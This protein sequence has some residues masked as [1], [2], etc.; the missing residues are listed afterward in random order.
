[1]D[2]EALVEALRSGQLY[3]AGL[4]VYAA[5]PEVPEAL[6]QLESAVLAP[7]LGSADF[8]ARQRMAEL[9]VAAV[10]A[11]LDGREPAHRVV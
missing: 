3:A 8:V 4:D 5:E 10:L 6:R 2:E 1:V 11:G 7:H 9:C